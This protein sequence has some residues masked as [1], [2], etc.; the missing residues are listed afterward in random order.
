MLFNTLSNVTNGSYCTEMLNR[1]LCYLVFPPCDQSNNI[2]VINPE[3]CQN[4]VV[5]GICA[6]HVEAMIEVLQ[7]KNMIEVAENLRNCSSPLLEPD[8]MLSSSFI[9]LPSML[10]HL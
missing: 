6:I 5:D 9:S 8:D 1:F 3:S 4:Y 10:L 2:E 7:D